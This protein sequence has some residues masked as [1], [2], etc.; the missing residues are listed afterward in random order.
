MLAMI[1]GLKWRIYM[2]RSI[3]FP[4]P[5]PGILLS[6]L[7]A[8]VWVQTSRAQSPPVDLTELSLEELLSV[9][10][11]DSSL[12]DNSS[13]GPANRNTRVSYRYVRNHFEDYVD[14]HRNRTSEDVLSDFPVVPSLIIQEAHIIS[15]THRASERA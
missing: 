8:L 2:M 14:G 6:A 15:V 9:Q 5:R 11:I 4:A 12:H 10:L 7:F 1:D 3:P 13:G